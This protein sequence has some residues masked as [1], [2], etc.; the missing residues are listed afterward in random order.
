M[1]MTQGKIFHDLMVD[2]VAINLSTQLEV[3][4]SKFKQ[5]MISLQGLKIENKVLLL[6]VLIISNNTRN[7]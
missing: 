4:E 7:P 1:F 2:S 3:T 5:K 6:I